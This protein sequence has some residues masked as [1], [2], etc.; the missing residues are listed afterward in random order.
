VLEAWHALLT[1]DAEVGRT[2]ALHLIERVEVHGERVLVAPKACGR[3]E[4]PSLLD[5]A[6]E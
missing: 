4:E 6:S 5:V 1:C 2:Y 3:N